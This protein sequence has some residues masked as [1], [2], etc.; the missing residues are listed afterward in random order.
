MVQKSID[1]YLGLI[2]QD[3]TKQDLAPLINL[4]NMMISQVVE[5][6]NRT[7]KKNNLSPTTIQNW[8]RRGIVPSPDGKKYSMS[9]VATILLLDDLRGI[10]SLEDAKKLL[11]F[12]NGD[13][14]ATDDDII[15]PTELYQLYIEMVD[16]AEERERNLSLRAEKALSKLESFSKEPDDKGKAVITLT[17]LSLLAEA[18]IN[19][20]MAQRWI[21]ILENV[22]E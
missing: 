9:Q 12:I 20:E 2:K 11:K 14:K 5:L 18:K 16:E 1:N 8:V 13:E 19:R 22:K 7:N 10:I 15:E 6:S 17:I 4:K 21:E 3:V